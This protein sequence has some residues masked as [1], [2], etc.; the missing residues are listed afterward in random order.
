MNISFTSNSFREYI[1]KLCLLLSLSSSSVPP[2]SGD[3]HS[4]NVP[5]ERAPCISL[6]PPVD[7]LNYALG[8]LRS[9]A[10]LRAAS[11]NRIAP[12]IA[13]HAHPRVYEP[14]FSPSHHHPAP[15]SP[16][17]SSTSPVASSEI[18]ASADTAVIVCWVF[19]S[20]VNEFNPE[21]SRPLS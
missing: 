14:L 5:V 17:P 18:N 2:S 9:I 11:I 1:N 6:Q 20:R 19:D 10:L 8:A 15:R 3:K 12:S 7:T 21:R 16:S 13:S 4:I